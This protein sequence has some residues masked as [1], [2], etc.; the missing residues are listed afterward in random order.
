MVPC[1]L[2]MIERIARVHDVHVFAL[3]QEPRPSRYELLGAHV[4]NIGARPQAA[5]AFHAIVA[6]HNRKPFDVLHA[7]WAVPQGVV[8]GLAGRVLRRPVL[9]HLTGGDLASVPAL[10]YGV[11]RTRLGR[12]QLQIAAALAACVTVPSVAMLESA[13]RRGI[14]AERLPYG[15]C[16]EHWPLIRPH[17]RVEPVAR[18]LHVASLN[19]IKDQRTLLRAAR[20]LRDWGVSFRLD[21]VGEDTLGG[22]VQ[23]FAA[24]LGLAE[25]VTF[26]GFVPQ[27]ELQPLM[28][29]AHLLLMSSRHE[30]DPIVL[31]EAAMAGIPTVGTAV[32]HLRTWAPAAAVAVPVGDARALAESAASLLADE[33]WR[34]EVARAA[35][36]IASTEDADWTA[37]RI[38]EIYDDLAEASFP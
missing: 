20:Y 14:P 33:T 32:G 4:H 16:R 26:H 28:R 29:R 17:S 22:E 3:R 11:L 8:A 38:L 25:L 24:E 6:E 30:A 1:L 9:L 23:A 27:A 36:A 5:R 7:V 12:V 35:Q 21:I 2:W 37:Q 31:L 13:L 10:S 19:R 15:V 18:L 34:L